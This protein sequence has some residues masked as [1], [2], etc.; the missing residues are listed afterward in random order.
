M[1]NLTIEDLL[2]LVRAYEPEK[3]DIV[4][5]AYNFADFLHSGQKRQSGEPYIIHP[6]NVA[7]ILAEMHADIDTICAGLLHDTLEDTKVTKEEIIKEFNEDVESLVD[8]VTKISKMNFST[9]LDE[10]LANTRKI[11]TSIATDVRIIIIKLADRLHNMRTLQ[12][13]SK[14]K[15]EENALETL[16]IFVPLAYYIG[17]YNIKS[18][19]EDLSFQYLKPDDYQNI[20]EQCLK[21]EQENEDYLKEMKNTIRNLLNENT[22]ENWIKIEMKNLYSVY[23]K[24]NQG[25]ELKS[26]HDLLAL[27]VAVK[28][29]ENCY[30]SLGLIH[31]KYHPVNA[32]FKDYICNPKNN[33]YQSLHTTVFG[34]NKR[35]VQIQIRDYDMDRVDKF[36]LAT[37]WYI[38]GSDAREKMQQ[39]LKEKY[40]FFKSL[41]VL[42]SEFNDNA[43]FV[44]KAKSEVFSNRIYVYTPDGI[45]IELPKGAT[46]IDFAYRLGANEGN[47]L[48]EA[49]VN[50][51]LV[52]L[53]YQLQNTDIVK[54]ICN[55]LSNG[56]KPEWL[57][58]TETTSA[59]R[60]IRESLNCTKAKT[61]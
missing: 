5:K 4:K 21:I 8:G 15:Q 2:N 28:T 39:E 35:L 43:E 31:S 47:H 48:V 41:N 13:K 11:I 27:K 52:P 45:I 29:F 55:D 17:A 22:I 32:L 20:N 19:L 16:E 24:L 10:D 61:N 54:I 6:L 51:N 60:L 44:K 18:E 9:R 50:D 58:M 46:P 59:K 57:D 25:S 30:Y 38:K 53:N 7:Y 1:N 37:Y 12:Y 33:M 34:E 14:E 3:I 40:Q 49:T 36:G 23:K 56:P 26:M 42:N